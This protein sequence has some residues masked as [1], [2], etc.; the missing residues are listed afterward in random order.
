MRFICPKHSVKPVVLLFHLIE[1]QIHKISSRGSHR[2]FQFL[3]MLQLVGIPSQNY[4]QCSPDTSV[5]TL[6]SASKLLEHCTPTVQQPLDMDCTV[7]SIVMAT[8]TAVEGRPL[9]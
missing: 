4:S 8:A 5:R 3:V 2:R 9:L 6:L 1:Y 7:Y